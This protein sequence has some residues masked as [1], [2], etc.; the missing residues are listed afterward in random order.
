MLFL[1][2]FNETLIFLPDFRRILKLNLIKIRSLGAGL[3]HAN[4]RKGMTKLTVAFLNFE[5]AYKNAWYQA[6]GALK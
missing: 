5:N 6:S 3:F 1:S 2:D 4:R